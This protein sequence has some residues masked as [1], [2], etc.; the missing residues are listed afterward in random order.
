MS[1]S[2]YADPTRPPIGPSAGRGSRGR[3]N[4]PRPDRR[5]WWAIV[6]GMVAVIMWG[7]QSIDVNWTGP[8]EVATPEPGSPL[9]STSEVDTLS[10]GATTRGE[11][12]F[13]ANGCGSCHSI[14]G[15][16][17][18][19]PTLLGVWGSKRIRSDG[20][21]TVVDEAYIGESIVNP[22]ALVVPGYMAQMPS[23]EGLLSTQD[24][25]GLAAYVR[26]L[27]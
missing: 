9:T 2:A 17:R 4:R 7:L 13:G 24:L 5:E 10:D 3:A 11:A 20:S 15:T 19:G 23:Y 18:I 8:A 16:E 26:T 25:T 12:L 1:S 22:M 14:D 27:R 6:L 21:L